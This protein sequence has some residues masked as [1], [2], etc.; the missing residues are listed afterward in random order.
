MAM[1]ALFPTWTIGI[2]EPYS[3]LISY[4]ANHLLT[5]IDEAKKPYITISILVV[6]VA[7]QAH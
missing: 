2:T 6:I 1:F 4:L 3:F 7:P 5:N